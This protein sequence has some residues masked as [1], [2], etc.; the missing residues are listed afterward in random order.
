MLKQSNGVSN[1]SQTWVEKQA[2]A[3]PAA[4]SSNIF[5]EGFLKVSFDDFDNHF[6]SIFQH[7]T[8]HGQLAAAN[9]SS[10]ND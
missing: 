10:S 3:E 1:L 6:A 7:T 9:G 2:N 5:A 8:V 4:H